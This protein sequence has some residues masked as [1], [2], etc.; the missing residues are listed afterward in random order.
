MSRFL[1]AHDVRD[2]PGMLDYLSHRTVETDS[3]L[4]V[5]RH[6]EVVTLCDLAGGDFVER[7]LVLAHAR[8]ERLRRLAWLGL[9]NPHYETVTLKGY[10]VA[11]T[12]MLR[13]LGDA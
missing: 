8:P 7:E 2:M 6:H 13:D 3:A 10:V 1:P 4:S 12:A 5:L 9:W 11:A